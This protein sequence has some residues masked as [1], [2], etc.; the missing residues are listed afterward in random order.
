MSATATN[1]HTLFL[2]TPWNIGL[3]LV[4]DALWDTNKQKCTWLGHSMEPV[5]GKFTS[6]VRSFGNDMYSGSSG[7]AFFLSALYSVKQDPLLHKTIEGAMAHTLSLM[8]SAAGFG[9]YSGKP[10]IASSLI[11][12]GE[13]LGRNEWIDAGLNLLASLKGIEAGDH[14]TDIISGIAGTIPCLITF[15]Q[16]YNKPELLEMATAMGHTLVS[17]AT[18]TQSGWSWLTIPGTNHLTG[19]SHGTAGIATSLLQ[20]YTVTGN[21]QF[22][23]AAQGAFEYEHTHFNHAQ[24]NWPDFRDNFPKGSNGTY[25]CGAAWCHG[26]P[27][28]ALSRL[29][30]SRLKPDPE[31]LQVATLALDTTLKDTNQMLSNPSYR[32]NYSLCHGVAGNADI[33]LESG[34]EQDKAA[35]TA[36]GL[37]GIEQYAQPRLP[38]PSGT[39]D[40]KRTPG[41]M[42]GMAGT[43]YFYL[44]LYDQAKFKT[45]LLA[46][47]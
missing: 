41:L 35:A 5:E 6:V 24:Q 37:A 32:P 42:M 46:E 26:A 25:N 34:R 16:R 27:G 12:C 8:N 23:E 20:L 13:T 17:K 40:N 4:R 36:V 19:Y 43:G 39:N 2:E 38:W 45:I 9:F 44:R 28:I 14:Q 7:I 15:A 47:V 11:Y 31:Y 1:Q 3:D 10:G 21:E 33:L 29:Q 18:R 30:A 22:L